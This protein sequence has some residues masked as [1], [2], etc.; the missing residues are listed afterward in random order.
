MPDLMGNSDR[1]LL[2]VLWVLYS[3]H[4]SMSGPTYPSNP[5]PTH[6]SLPPTQIRSHGPALIHLDFSKFLPPPL[7]DFPLVVVVEYVS[8]FRMKSRVL[9]LDLIPPTE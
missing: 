6:L 2:D 7:F 9:H 4:D 1:L 5:V 8:E 3:A